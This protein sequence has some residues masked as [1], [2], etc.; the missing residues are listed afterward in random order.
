[1]KD[2][3]KILISTLFVLYWLGILVFNIMIF[4]GWLETATNPFVMLGLSVGILIM[5]FAIL[6]ILGVTYIYISDKYTVRK[7][8]KNIQKTPDEYEVPEDEL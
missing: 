1:M 8:E 2:L 7:H 5:I 4:W 6:V 3:Y